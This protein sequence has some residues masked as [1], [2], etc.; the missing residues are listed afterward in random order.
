MTDEM[1]AVGCPSGCG[2]YC[3]C[4]KSKIRLASSCV[5][6][7][8]SY[9]LLT[10]QPLTPR[11]KREQERERCEVSTRKLAIEKLFGKRDESENRGIGGAKVHLS[12]AERK[13]IERFIGV[14]V[15]DAQDARRKMKERGFRFIERGEEMDNRL[16]LQKEWAEAGGE[17]A[18]VPL[19]DGAGFPGWDKLGMMKTPE[20]FDFA[21]RLTYHRNRLGS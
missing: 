8:I 4:G 9:K 2:Q 20:P 14:P 11:E 13:S 1:V 15:E 5:K 10:A 19:P 17:K 12:A 21:D 7:G 3:G 6:R 16:R 18:G